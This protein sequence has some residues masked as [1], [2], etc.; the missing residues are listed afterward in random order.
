MVAQICPPILR[1][2]VVPPWLWSARR[3]PHRWPTP[4]LSD[5]SRLSGCLF[6]P[7]FGPPA[8]CKVAA[9]EWLF[10]APG[11]SPIP[12]VMTRRSAFAVFLTLVLFV[13]SVAFGAAR[14]QARVAGQ[15]VLCLGGAAVSVAVDQ[16]GQPVGTVHLCPDCALGSLAAIA[17]PGAAAPVPVDRASRVGWSLSGSHSVPLWRSRPVARGPPMGLV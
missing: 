12:C 6:G 1:G 3:S 15:V 17:L 8:C 11:T 4:P 5:A 14:G 16:D 9:R 10:P 2:P 7:S 13:T